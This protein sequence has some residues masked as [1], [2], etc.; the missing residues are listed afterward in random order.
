MPIKQA[1]NLLEIKYNSV[2]GLIKIFKDEKRIEVKK[3]V[4]KKP[5]LLSEEIINK[6]EEYIKV[7]SCSTLKAIKN[8]ILETFGVSCCI[9]TVRRAI[10]GMKITKKF[11]A[12]TLEK[13]NNHEILEKRKLY[14]TNFLTNSPENDNKIIF[15][16]ES[17]FNLHFRPSF[18][19]SHI[20]K[21]SSVSVPCCLE[22][23][24]LHLEKVV[25]HLEKVVIELEIV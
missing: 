22:K 12:R 18:G 1:S 14:A 9:E 25:L 24:V 4:G 3:E 16:G 19:K 23:V 7:N 13:V 11:C 15:M 20:G 10:V 8:K 6:I 5:K 2:K 21:R 17:G